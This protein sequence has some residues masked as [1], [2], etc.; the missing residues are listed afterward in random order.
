MEI[1][2]P[3]LKRYQK[4]FNFSYSFGIYPTLELLKWKRDSVLKV[5]LK[6]DS[7]KFPGIGEII[8]ICKEKNVEMEYNDR[9][10]D[11]IAYKENTYAMGVF[12]KYDCEINE[13]SNHILLDEPRNM[14]NL[15]TIVRSMVGY[16]F[17]DLVI[18]G[19]GVDIFD[20]K[21]IS[22]TAGAFFKISFAYFRTVEEYIRTFPNHNLYKF[23]LKGSKNILDV[24]FKESFTLVFG[25][26]MEGLSK[27]YENLGEGVYI[28]H[29]NEIESLNLSVAASIGMW[30]ASRRKKI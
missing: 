26:E 30:E 23:L 11:R 17:K 6:K 3:Q 15:G 19:M 5:F 2:N 4:K 16:G 8:D 14:G 9:V 21:V 1:R 18:V 28:P 7:K 25:N 10:V 29:S 27:E 13:N 24:E 20:P 22:S 12:E